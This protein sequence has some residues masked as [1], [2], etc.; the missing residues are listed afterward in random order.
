METTPLK[1]SPF[2]A[3]RIALGTWAI[4]GWMWGGTDDET[5]IRTIHAA[6]DQGINL[7]DTAPVYGFGKSEELVGEAI[8]RRGGRDRVLIATKVGLEWTAEEAVLRNASADRI[9]AEVE[10]SLRRLQTDYIDLYQVHWPDPVTPMEETAEAMGRLLREGKIRAVGV[11]NFSPAQ[12]DTFRK[13]GPLHACQPPYNLFERGIEADVLPYCRENGITILAYGALCRGLLS[14]RMGPDTR[15]DGD[16]LRQSD[17]KFQSPRFDQYLAAVQALDHFARERFESD[18]LHLAVRWLLDQGAD[19]AL[20]GARRPEQV[21]TV[22]RVMDIGLTGEDRDQI[23][24]ILDTHITD[25]VG[26]EF[27]APPARNG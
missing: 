1:G 14:G 15:F 20:W 3:S 25:P 6:L 19:I 4:G 26:P 12:M 7:I 27:M 8:R 21:A 16:D 2:E 23:D 9:R 13:I 24:R 11:S 10:D 17:P 5:S 22:H 18:V